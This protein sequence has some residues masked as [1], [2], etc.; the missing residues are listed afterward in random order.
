M[1]I[2]RG[3]HGVVN[4]RSHEKQNLKESQLIGPLRRHRVGAAPKVLAKL[5]ED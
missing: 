1:V 5:D 3:N 4:E 2:G